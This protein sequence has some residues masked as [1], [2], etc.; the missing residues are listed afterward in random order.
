VPL[1]GLISTAALARITWLRQFGKP[2]QTVSAA[3]NNAV[4]GQSHSIS[5]KGRQVIHE[6][7]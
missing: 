4:I 3:A 2:F 6:S 7:R 5:E 1:L